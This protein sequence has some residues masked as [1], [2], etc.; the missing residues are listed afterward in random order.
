[1]AVLAEYRDAQRDADIA[2]LRRVVALRAL[3]AE[4]M[5]QRQI[6]E[7]LGVSQPA[8]SQQLSAAPDLSTVHPEL[9][10]AAAAPVVKALA[11]ERGFERL[12][13]FGSVARG[14]ARIDS[15]IDLLIASPPGTSSFAFLRF[16]QLIEKSLGRVVD[17]V[18]YGGL[19][20]GMDD[21]ILRDAV[22]L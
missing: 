10:L 4:G 22:L 5:S 1:M 21:D 12:A 19:K 14:E 20:P 2:R 17:L 15:D 13:V 9:L 8:I 7:E 18:D 16:K 11:A 3:V 6:A